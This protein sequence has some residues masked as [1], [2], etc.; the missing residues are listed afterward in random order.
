[1]PPCH[2]STI[3]PSGTE[4][5]HDNPGKKQYPTSV[6]EELSA[7]CCERLQT[8]FLFMSSSYGV[9][10][11]AAIKS[12]VSNSIPRSMIRGKIVRETHEG[13]SL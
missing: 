10:S 8:T 11:P 9:G 12:H 4:H 6:E 5:K 3:F 7:I 2:S 13:I 1:M